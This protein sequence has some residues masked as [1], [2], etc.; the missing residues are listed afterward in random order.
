[1]VLAKQLLA[2]GLIPVVQDKGYEVT[3]VH[4]PYGT[5]ISNNL[6]HMIFL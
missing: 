4:P 3:Y 6:V 2:R 5:D 1:M